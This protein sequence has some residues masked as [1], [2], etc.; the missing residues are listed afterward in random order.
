M[1]RDELPAYSASLAAL[2]RSAHAS[3]KPAWSEGHAEVGMG[4]M[5]MGERP[6]GAGRRG[7]WSVPLGRDNEKKP[8]RQMTVASR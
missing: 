4:G 3:T 6:R 5:F 8:A 1:R 2:H 7:R